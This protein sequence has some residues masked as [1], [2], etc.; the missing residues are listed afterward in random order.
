M[1]HI[2]ILD[3]YQNLA[4]DLADWSHL[5][6][7]HRL[8]VHDRPLLGDALIEALQPADVVC[9]MRERT[10]F[11]AEVI[12]R[13]PNL[14]AIVTAGMRNAAIDVA[15]AKARGIVVSGTPARSH[16][17]AD[18][19]LGLMLSLFRHIPHEA[20]NM[21]D[22]GWQSTVGFEVTGKTL[23]LIGLGKLGTRVARYGTALGMNVIAWSTN[24][25]D[26]AAEA[27]G[28]RRVTFE[29]L[30]SDA[31]V[32]SIHTR[33]SE[34]TRGLIDSRAFAAMKPT[35][36]LINTSRG[37]IVDEA[38]M[39]EAL[40]SSQIAGAALDVF[41]DEPLPADHPLR[42]LPNTILTPHLGYWTRENLAAWYQGMAESTA[43]FL[44]GAPIRVIGD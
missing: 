41:D 25:T 38:A 4:T 7:E 15:A 23:G 16:A 3:D 42:Q 32:V 14:K 10:A 29:T 6:S 40:Q 18:L 5:T 39:I 30:I 44:D 17:T 27:C 22:G 8:A 26:E 19:T 20:Q 35:A 33:L 36:F 24:L 31:D 11:N 43:A 2:A 9:L 37:P 13:L 28:T 21:R 34:R 12:G 1:A